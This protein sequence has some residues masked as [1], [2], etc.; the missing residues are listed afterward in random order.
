MPSRRALL[1]ESF[2][3]HACPSYISSDFIVCL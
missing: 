2:V 1:L 3:G